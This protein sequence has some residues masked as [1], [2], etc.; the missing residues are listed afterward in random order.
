MHG[1]D[2]DNRHMRRTSAGL[3]LSFALADDEIFFFFFGFEKKM[4]RNEKFLSKAIKSIGKTKTVK[5]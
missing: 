3:L 5:K 1:E 2:S 4:R